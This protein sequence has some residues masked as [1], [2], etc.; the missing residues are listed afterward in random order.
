MTPATV[1]AFPARQISLLVTHAPSCAVGGRLIYATCTVLRDENERV[2]ERFLGERSDFVV[3]PLKE[4]WGGARAKELGQ[5]DDGFLRLS[6]ERHD[7]DGFFAA[8]M[9]RVR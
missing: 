6:P 1:A 7:T 2:V 4:I 5:A 8:V 9:R 3:A